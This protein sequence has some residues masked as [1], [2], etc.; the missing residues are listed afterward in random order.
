MFWHPVGVA[1]GGCV[2][3]SVSLQARE[4]LLGM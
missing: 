1:A 2:Q 4:A 3:G